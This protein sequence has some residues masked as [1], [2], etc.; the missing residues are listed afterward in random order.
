MGR[1]VKKSRFGNTAGDFEVTGAFATGTTQPDGTG[2]EAVSTASGNYIVAQRSSTRYKVNFTSADG[3]SRLEQILDLKPVAT[4]SLTNG[5]FCI[6]I[7]LDDSTVAYASKIFNNTVHYKTAGGVTGS[8][9]Y[10]LSSEGEDEGAN[11]GV[12]S[13]DTI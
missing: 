9:K 2:A 10:S 1:P 12:G 5:Q 8:V 11:S 13:I 3:S 7:I 6:Q 4:G